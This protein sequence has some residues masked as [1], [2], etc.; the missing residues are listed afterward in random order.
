M[1]RKRQVKRKRI[2]RTSKKEK[3]GMEKKGRGIDGE[4]K[5]EAEDNKGR[6]GNE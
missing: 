4:S 3:K 5:T 6:R 2:E 1:E